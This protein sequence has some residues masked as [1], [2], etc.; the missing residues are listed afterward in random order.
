MLPAASR[1]STGSNPEANFLRR[2]TGRP[3]TSTRFNN[4]GGGFRVANIGDKADVQLDYT[5]AEGNTEIDVLQ[6][7]R[8]TKSVSGS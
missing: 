1:T 3:I 4:Y 7:C 2:R 6:R 5:R 8:R